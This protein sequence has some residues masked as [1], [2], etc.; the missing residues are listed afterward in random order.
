MNNKK[1]ENYELVEGDVTKTLDK[2]LKKYKFKNII[3]HLDM[4]VFKATQFVLNKLKNRIVKN[5]I[6]LIDDYGSVHG[7]TKAVDIFLK[8]T[9]T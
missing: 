4:D 1:F 2:F 6:I 9:K 3:T 8:K 5:G 7:A